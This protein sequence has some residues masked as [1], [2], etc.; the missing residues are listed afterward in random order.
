MIKVHVVCF[1]FLMEI[2]EN[3]GIRIG[4]NLRSNSWKKLWRRVKVG[5]N[6]TSERN[7]Y[8]FEVRVIDEH[9]TV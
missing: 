9:L 5:N 2:N 4:L 1:S 6:N 7:N 8:V 3:V